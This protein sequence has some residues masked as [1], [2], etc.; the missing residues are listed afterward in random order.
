MQGMMSTLGAVPQGAAIST[1]PSD[2]QKGLIKGLTNE[3][4]G[5]CSTGGALASREAR[6]VQSVTPHWSGP[7]ACNLTITKTTVETE[8][9]TCAVQCSAMQCAHIYVQHVSMHSSDTCRRTELWMVT[10]SL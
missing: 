2:V 5:F 7:S 6:D 3:I 10:V 9:S 8:V 1:C 4:R